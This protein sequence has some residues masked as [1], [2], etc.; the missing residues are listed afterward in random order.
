MTEYSARYDEERNNYRIENYRTERIEYFC[1]TRHN[2]I[3]IWYLL[4]HII[5]KQQ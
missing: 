2:K 3:Y 4:I 1:M 5:I